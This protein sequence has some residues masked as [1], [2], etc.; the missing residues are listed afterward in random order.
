VGDTELVLDVHDASSSAAERVVEH[1][2]A[3]GIERVIVASEHTALIHRVRALEPKLHTAATPRQAWRKLVGDAVRLPFLTPS[4]CTWMV[5]ERHRGLRVVTPRF[6]H[7]ARS[8]GDD[9]WVYVVDDAGRASQLRQWGVNGCF[10][11]APRALAQGLQR[12]QDAEHQAVAT[13]AGNVMTTLA[14]GAGAR[15]V[16]GASR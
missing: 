9:V 4:G 8:R 14:R 15:D 2:R 5:P 11:T 16:G 6:V 7:N 13:G 1:V 10:T 12:L 3:Y